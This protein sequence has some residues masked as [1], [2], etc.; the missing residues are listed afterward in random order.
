[1]LADY[2]GLGAAL[3]AIAGIELLACGLA[4]L[5]PRKVYDP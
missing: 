3:I 2:Q 4:L 5:V 1:V